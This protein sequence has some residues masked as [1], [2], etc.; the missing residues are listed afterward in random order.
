[1]V[2]SFSITT[3][4]GTVER[5]LVAFHCY[6]GG[7]KNQAAFTAAFPNKE[8]YFTECTG[9]VH[10]CT[11]LQPRLPLMC[12]AAPSAVGSGV[13]SRYKAASLYVQALLA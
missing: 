13:T 4:Y 1:V 11:P 7:Y 5:A 10:S 3:T 9:Y 6:A 2:R 12:H 8:V